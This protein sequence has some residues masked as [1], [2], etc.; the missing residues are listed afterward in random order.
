MLADELDRA[1]LLRRVELLV[2]THRGDARN[3]LATV[4]P[5]MQEDAEVAGL[6]G[7]LLNVAGG[8]GREE[9]YW[10][11]VVVILVMFGESSVCMVYRGMGV[12]TK[13][14][15]GGGVRA[16][17]CGV[18]SCCKVGDV[19]VYIRGGRAQAGITCWRGQPDSRL[20]DSQTRN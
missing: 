6:E 18:R 1:I 2:E 17:G 8:E 19:C 3:L 13:R 10:V 7:L 12:R 15:T 4:A 11:F 20:G 16:S 9:A 5:D 14:L